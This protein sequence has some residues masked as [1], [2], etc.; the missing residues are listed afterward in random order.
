MEKIKVSQ[1]FLYN[2]L[3]EHNIIFSMVSG[4]MGVSSDIVRQCL[5][6]DLNRLGKPMKLSAAN[7]E[8]MNVALEQIANELRQCVFTLE[9]KDTRDNHRGT[10]YYQGCVA[11]F[12]RINEYF[13]LNGL[14]ER[15]LGWNKTKCRTTLFIE[16]SPV[17]G[18]ITK[19]D[20][21]RINAELLAVAGVLSSYEVVADADGSI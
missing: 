7:I 2:Y 5:R 8:R 20:V 17:Y 3:Q 9:N 15:I 19:E 14:T 13:K 11:D 18:N 6:R 10:T 12:K 1:D 21:D 16:N 4:K